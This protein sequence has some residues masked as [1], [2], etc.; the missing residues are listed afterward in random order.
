[1]TF[2]FN[3]RQVSFEQGDSVL[4]AV[5]RAGQ[6]PTGGGCLC[7]AGDCPH[8]L[9]TVD[10]V[11][12]VRTCQTRA[13]TG[14]EVSRQAAQPELPSTGRVPEVTPESRFC[15]VVVIGQGESG[16]A[17]AALA[18][19]EG[20]S[21]ITFEAND[22][23]EVVG[24]YAG[25]LVVA[26][27]RARIVQVQCDEVVVATGAAEIQPVCPGAG[28][29]G[30]VTARAAAA[31]EA[32]GI[33]L[34]RTVR[35]DASGEWPVRFEGDERVS[36]VVVATAAG[37]VRHEADTVVVDLGTHPRDAL[38]RMGAGLNV[39]ALGDAALPGVLPPPPRDGVICPCSGVTVGD[40]ESV[41]E[42]GFREMEL[43]KRAT[44]AGT[45]TCQ[46][47]VCLPHLRAFLTGKGVSE[48][49]PF[50]ARPLVRQI[51]MAEAGAA[52]HSTPFKRTALHDEHLALGAQMD[53]FGGWWRP[54]RYG[55]VEAEYRAV[56]EAV[57]VG[58]VGTLGKIIVSGPG[59][60]DLLDWLYPCRVADLRPGRCRYALLL[61]ERGYVIEDG[62]ICRD[63][64]TRFY[65]SF[66]SAGASFAEMWVRDWAEGLDLDVR[67]MDRTMSLGA[68]NVTGPRAKDL[69]GRAGF[70]TPLPYMSH[71]Q[72]EVFGVPC[73]VLRLSFTGE[74]SFEL[75]HPVDR[76]VD[77]WNALLEAGVDLGVRP[78]GL[79][80]LFTL[81]L[82][83]GHVIVGMDTEFDS[84]PR[85]LGMDWAVRMD[86]GDFVGRE[87]LS[88][89]NALPLDKLL[90]GLQMEGT[91]PFEGEVIWRSGRAVGQVTSARFS[92]ML[93][94][95]VMLGWVAIEDGDA[96]DL[97]EVDG[98]PARRTTTPFYDP[99]GRRA[100]S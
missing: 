6:H 47:S 37:N 8:C 44:L 74:V 43:I 91:D 17:A 71:A 63:T 1:M 100:R 34:G 50:T 78:H 23:E 90:I 7:L 35:I 86:K 69:L 19:Q 61:D 94:K 13:G 16:V 68:I 54:W 97:V 21:V 11:S 98:R 79:D 56:R 46:G 93:Q 9:A 70:T 20:R 32:A 26:R 40:V 33:E 45:G 36:A 95:A 31:L 12:Y 42:R 82:E 15:D 24:I 96:P 87:A 65:L 3:G 84:T 59:A 81:R 14:M 64:A 4:V 80:A 85:R 67:I 72:A 60:L 83:K 73:R 25:P 75:H 99:E 62:L 10:G 27:T 29:A 89:T 57:S 76:S 48:V 52:Y 41:W 18:R 49:M 2:T 51:T 30:I 55:A 28:L 5:L 66:T 77:L 22:G 88:R 38:V 39:R 92:P 53:R 58:D